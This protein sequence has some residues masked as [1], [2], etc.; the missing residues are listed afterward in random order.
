M[1]RVYAYLTKTRNIS[2]E[3]VNEFVSKG[4]IIEDER[5]NLTF[6]MKDKEDNIIGVVKKK[7]GYIK[8]NYINTQ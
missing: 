3:T 8:L 7:Q 5:H 2:A 1:R 4:L 6:K